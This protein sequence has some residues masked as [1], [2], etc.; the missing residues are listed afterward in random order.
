MTHPKP[1]QQRQASIHLPSN[2]DGQ[3][4]VFGKVVKG[5]NVLDK[6]VRGEL[7]AKSSMKRMYII[8][9]KK[10]KEKHDSFTFQTATI[11]RPITRA[12]ASPISK[13]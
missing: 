2:F 9:K 11:L 13:P 8:E 3:Y 6:V 1:E 4:K 7:P 12:T 5:I 10:G